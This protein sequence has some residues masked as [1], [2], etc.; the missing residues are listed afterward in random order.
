MCPRW[1]ERI[2]QAAAERAVPAMARPRHTRSR[3]A[4]QTA[5]TTRA[6]GQ[7]HLEA[8]HGAEDV[9]RL[10]GSHVLRDSVQVERGGGMGRVA[11]LQKVQGGT[12]SGGALERT[13][14]RG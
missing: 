1:K 11:L 6:A 14:G 4:Q 7:A 2:T 12:R 10:T 5:R 9:R 13:L 8:L 3:G